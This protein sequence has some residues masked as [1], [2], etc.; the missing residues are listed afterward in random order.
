VVA[1]VPAGRGRRQL[2]HP[3]VPGN[4]AGVASAMDETRVQRG[5]DAGANRRRH[6]IYAGR[7]SSGADRARRNV[8]GALRTRT[9]QAEE[10]CLV[11]NSLRSKRELQMEIVKAT[12][13]AAESEPV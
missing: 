9:Q 1:R 3:D 12:V 10:G 8:H 11:A 6:E 7:H 13:A 5:G 4:G 2:F